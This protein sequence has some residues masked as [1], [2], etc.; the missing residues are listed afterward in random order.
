MLAALIDALPDPV[1]ALR[2]GEIVSS[3]RAFRSAFGESNGDLFDEAGRR[4]PKDRR[5]L[6]RAMEAEEFEMRV[7]VGSA[8]GP[9]FEARSERIETSDGPIS[10]LFLR[11]L[12]G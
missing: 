6:S 7:R 3:N 10:I 11:Q 12:A 9:L 8:G 5:P 1:V 4:L 2:G